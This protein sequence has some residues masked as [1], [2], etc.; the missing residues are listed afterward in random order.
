MPEGPAPEDGSDALPPLPPSEPIPGQEDG[1]HR[2]KHKRKHR[3]ED[4]SQEMLPASRRSKA[5]ED[6]EPAMPAA[7]S[8]GKA[9]LQHNPT[10]VQGKDREAEGIRD[11]ERHQ[12]RL[13]R[14]HKSRDGESDVPSTQEGERRR[15]RDSHRHKEKDGSRRHRDDDRGERHTSSKGRDRDEDR[16]RRR[17]RHDS[18]R[19]DKSR[20]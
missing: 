8:N 2:H 4:L 9:A 1:K 13:E 20:R 16:G 7:H 6:A 19:E 18:G 5:Y 12:H 14:K 10:E 3:D 11:K 15:D 17:H